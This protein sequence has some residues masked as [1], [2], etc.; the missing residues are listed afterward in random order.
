MKMKN[1][2]LDCFE[3][4]MSMTFYIYILDDFKGLEGRVI[5]FLWKELTVTGQG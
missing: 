5:E 3:V 1:G 4:V 2:E